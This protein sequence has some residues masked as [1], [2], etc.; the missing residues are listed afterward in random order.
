MPQDCGL[1]TGIRADGDCGRGD[2]AMPKRST[3]KLT[4]RIVEKL[5][6]EDKDAMH[7]AGLRPAH[8]NQQRRTPQKAVRDGTP[9]NP[10]RSS[11]TGTTVKCG[12]NFGRVSPES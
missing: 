5:K 9:P 7:R 6:A 4:K 11:P 8:R 2:A 12:Q 10:G 3:L 1:V